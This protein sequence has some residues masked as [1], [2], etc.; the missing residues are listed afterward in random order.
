MEKRYLNFWVKKKKRKRGNRNLLLIGSL[1]ISLIGFMI[2]VSALTDDERQSLQSELDSLSAELGGEGLG[3][4]VNYNISYLNVEVY[5]EGDDEV[6]AVFE[7][8]T[9]VNGSF[10]KIIE[11]QGFAM[12]NIKFKGFNESQDF[13]LTNNKIFYFTERRFR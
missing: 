1:L 10:A 12:V 11:T 5:R 2:L 9:N 4:L 3:W 8:I 7:N 6:L 13:V